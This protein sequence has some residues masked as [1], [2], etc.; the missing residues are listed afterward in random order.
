VITKEKEIKNDEK[1]ACLLKEN[2]EH[3]EWQH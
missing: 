1:W 3:D 2:I